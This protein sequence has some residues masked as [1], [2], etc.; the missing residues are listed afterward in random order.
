MIQ[1]AIITLAPGC[2]A[3]YDSLS[4]ITLNMDKKEAK[5]TK[6]MNVTGLIKAVKDGKIFVTSGT[7]ESPKVDCL[8]SYYRLLDKK[9][10]NILKYQNKNAATNEAKKE[11]FII[12]E[13]VKQEAYSNQEKIEEKENIEEVLIEENNTPKKR[14]RKKKE[15]LKE[16]E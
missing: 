14:T 12:F 2:N 9:K 4:G 5:V 11:D 6:N 3:F 1:V 13:E 8:P 16:E 10:K 15:I 7:L